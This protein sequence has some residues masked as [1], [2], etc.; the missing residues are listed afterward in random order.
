[1]NRLSWAGVLAQGRKGSK[2]SPR[3]DRGPEPGATART[4]EQIRRGITLMDRTSGE[5]NRGIPR[6]F[7]WLCAGF[8][9]PK[10]PQ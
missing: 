6:F 4:E 2:K 9:K 3:P 1:M 5:G 7:S 8:R 10:R